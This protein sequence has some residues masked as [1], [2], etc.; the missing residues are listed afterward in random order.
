MGSDSRTQLSEEE[1]VINAPGL[2]AKDWETE[3]CLTLGCNVRGE[4]KTVIKQLPRE[5]HSIP[6]LILDELL[7]PYRFKRE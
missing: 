5:S 2:A 3:G 7:I 1:D 6:F 4:A